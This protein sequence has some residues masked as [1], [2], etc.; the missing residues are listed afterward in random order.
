MSLQ[1]I[2]VGTRHCRLLIPNS[3]FPIPNSQLLTA[4]RR[5]CRVPTINHSRETALP[6]PHSQCPIPNAQFPM[7]NSQ[8]PFDQL[9]ILIEKPAAQSLS[10]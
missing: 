2:I 10:Q 4:R 6:S 8:L 1:L 3:Q 9:C 7:P 5:Q